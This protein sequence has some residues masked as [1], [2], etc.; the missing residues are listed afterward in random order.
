MIKKRLFGFVLS[1]FMTLGVTFF[2]SSRNVNKVSATGEVQFEFDSIAWNNIDYSADTSGGRIWTGD[3]NANGSPK[4]GYC[5]LAFFKEQGKTAQQSY[6]G[7]VN[8]SGR[9]LIGKGDSVD[10]KVK[11]N[12][13]NIVDVEG[14][15]CYIYPSYGLL[16]YVPEASLTYDET[17]TLPT[18]TLESGFH[19]DNVYF[20]YISFEFRGELGQTSCWSYLKDPSEYNRFDF[21]Q[22][23]P[24]WN[25]TKAD[26]THNQTI[27]QFGEY[28]VNYLKNDTIS[29][30]I[31]L[32]NQYSDCGK[33]ITING[34]PL[35]QYEDC[36]VSYLHGYCYAYFVFPVSALSPSNGYKV[37]T[38]HISADTIFYDTMLPEV[39]LYLFKGQWVTVRPETPADS[40]YVGALSL[41][42]TFGSETIT[43]DE[44]NRQVN[45][46]GEKTLENFGLFID[47]KLLTSDSA[48]V[49]YA[50]GARNQA[51]L[52]LVFRDNSITLY[53]STQNNVLLSSIELEPFDY[54][55]WYSLFL[56]TRVVDNKLSIYLAIDDITY[57]HLDN[58]RLSSTSNIGNLFSIVLGEGSASFK[59]AVLG[60]DNKK[61]TLSY[62]GKKAYGVLTG[63]DV[64]DFT[65]RCTAYDTHDGD[66]TNLIQYN[67]PEGAIT[68][69]KINKGTWVVEIVAVDLSNNAAKMSITVVATNKLD[70]VVTFDGENP[71]EYRVGDCIAP[72]ADPVKEGDGV[73]SYRFVGWYYND[74][75]WDF[76]NDYIVADMNLVSRF[77]E[78]V[79]EYCVTF[80]VE[81]LSGLSSFTM[82]FAY[83]TRLNMNMFARDGYSLVAY[84]NDNEVESIVVTQNMSVKLVYTSLNPKPNKKSGCGGSIVATSAILSTLALMG[85]ALISL[86]KKGGKEHE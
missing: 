38:L 49:L 60:E 76:E 65:I 20:P 53:D 28:G 14:S 78:V 77:Q 72:I 1:L 33:K 73:T 2:A 37:V 67:W 15:F 16:F 26:S 61:P 5:I 40:D 84:V 47:Y 24:G 75:L 58:I 45:G 50:L 23:A 18:I 34:I 9:G 59:N 80:T 54:D 42:S 85:V 57:I 70:V 13:V 62:T 8:T 41:S 63:S 7:E 81:G 25:N 3:V 21:V 27:L 56:Y 83:N 55:E 35:W 68:N 11:A 71:V 19:I 43:L 46:T 86:K 48:F 30:S 29:D 4:N 17:Y 12:G 69:N 52:R 74:R 32:V 64:L 79:E 44:N 36:I 6:I 31:N 22:V 10:T 82:Y 51:G 66:V 39:N